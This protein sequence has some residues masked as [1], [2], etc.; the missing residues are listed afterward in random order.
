[1]RSECPS[2]IRKQK[3]LVVSWSDGDSDS[4]DEY[5]SAKYAK[6]LSGICK[7]EEVDEL[8]YDELRACYKQLCD[9]SKVLESELEHQTSQLVELKRENSDLLSSIL[10]HKEEKEELNATMEDLEIE[11]SI[12]NYKLETLN[13]ELHAERSAKQK[14]S[15]KKSVPAQQKSRQMLQHPAPHQKSSFRSNHQEKTCYYCGAESYL[16]KLK[17]CPTSYVTFG[18]GAKGEIKGV[19]K[20]VNNG[21]PKL[22]NVL[23]VKGLTVN[24]IS[25]SQLC[26]LDLH[27]NFTK[28]GCNV[29]NDK[30]EVLMKGIRSKDN[31]YLWV[32]QDSENIST[33]LMSKEDNVRLWHQR[34]GHLHLRGLKKAMST[35]AVRGL[36]DLK[37]EERIICGECQ[38]GK[39]TKVPY[40]K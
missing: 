22:D 28:S 6:A 24:L 5:E 36:P 23:I 17:T 38:I 31:C 40:P 27:V 20:L 1:M 33:C 29:T 12:L 9:E 14:A 4:E 19:G 7:P 25:I 18:D 21:L 30:Q 8:T 11:V 39:Q 2:F 3:G 37:I 16:T 13:R 34:L 15:P 26:D 35:E 10:R 32:P